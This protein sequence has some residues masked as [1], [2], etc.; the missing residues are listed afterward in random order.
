MNENFLVV[1]FFGLELKNFIMLVSGCFGF[2]KEYGKYYDLN[3]FGLIMV[4]VMI[5]NVCFG[6][7]I[8]R[9]V[10]ILFGM[11]NVIGL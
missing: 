6:N 8:L 7:F 5:L 4:K 11:L 2:G 10:E 3:Q 9:V 1:K